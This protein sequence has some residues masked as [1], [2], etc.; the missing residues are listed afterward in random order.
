LALDGVPSHQAS[1]PAGTPVRDDTQI[2]IDDNLKEVLASWPSIPP[3]MREAIVA[4]IRSV[5]HGCG[6]GTDSH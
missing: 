4:I 3:A 6:H 2:T 1:Q 5:L